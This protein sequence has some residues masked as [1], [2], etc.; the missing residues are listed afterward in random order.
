MAL[1][2]AVITLVA[3]FGPAR[4]TRCQNRSRRGEIRHHQS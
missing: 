2:L 4:L 1:W 3:A